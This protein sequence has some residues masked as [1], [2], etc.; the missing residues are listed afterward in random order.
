MGKFITKKIIVK[1]LR[2]GVKILSKFI[3]NSDLRKI[4]FKTRLSGQKLLLENKVRKISDLNI[5]RLNFI[6]SENIFRFNLHEF[7]IDWTC[8]PSTI[9]S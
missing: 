1:F 4:K 6:F 7:T 9:L 3:K 2:E 5:F 8:F